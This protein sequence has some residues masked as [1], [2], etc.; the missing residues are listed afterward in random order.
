V[1]SLAEDEDDLGTDEGNDQFPTSEGM[2]DVGF[3][4]TQ[5]E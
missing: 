5:G 1:E 2:E 3:T 4:V